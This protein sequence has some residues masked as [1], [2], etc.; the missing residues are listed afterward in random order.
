MKKEAKKKVQGLINKYQKAK[1]DGKLKSYTEEETKKDFILPLFEILGWDVH[2]KNEVSAEESISGKRV[3]YGFYINN[4]VKFYLEAKKI[5]VDLHKEDYANQAIRYAW[6]KGAV[7]ALLTDFESII[8]F[9]AQDIERKLGDKLYFEIRYT[10]YLDRF[11]QLWLLSKEAF[12]NDEL[13]KDAEK[14]G[15]KF[16]KVPV[17]S[18]LYEDLE[19]CREIL[20]K[21]LGQMNRKVD[22]DLLDEGVQKLLDRLIFIRVAE[23]RGIEPK[24]LIPLVRQARKKGGVEIYQSMVEKFREFDDYYNSNLFLPHPFEKWE[25]YSGVTEKVISIL[26]G[27]EGYYE[28]DFKAMPAD[29]L[30]AVYENY[31]GHRLAQSKKGVA[32]SKD[33]RK[34]KEQGIYYTPNFIVDYIVRNTLKPVLD[35]CKTTEDIK[36]IRVLDPACGS[37]SFLVKALEIIVDKYK[38]FEVKKPMDLIKLQ[39]LEDNIY[40]VDLDNQAVELARLNLL[41]NVL[42]KR[43]KL[44][45]LD[46]IKNGNSLIFGTDKELEKYFGENFGEEKPFNWKEEFP[47]VVNQGGFDVIIGN[48]PYVTQKKSEVFNYEWNADLY[49]MFFELALKHNLL[50]EGGYLGYITPRFF[51]VNK[52]TKDVRDYMLKNISI[53]ALVE[54]SPFLDA[55]TECVITIIK[56]VE[57]ENKEIP[58]FKEKDGVVTYMNDIGISSIIQNP[59]SIILTDLTE[60]ISSLLKKIKKNSVSLKD[61]S[62]SRRGME[63]S[64]KDLRNKGNVKALIGEDVNRYSIAYENTHV[65]SGHKEYKRLKDFFRKKNLILLRRVAKCLISTISP[66]VYAFSKNIYGIKITDSNYNPKY[67]LALINS[68]LLSFYYQ[69]KF[70]TKKTSLFPEV[71]TYLFNKLPIKKID[72]TQQN[73]F[74]R[75]VNRILKLQKDLNNSAKNSNKWRMLKDKIEKV[76]KKINKK[77]YKVYGLTKKD[78]KIIEKSFDNN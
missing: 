58:I 59:D 64:K 15:K 13:D 52:N 61:I 43:E 32:V 7:W 14:H 28:Y 25:D 72:K 76:D 23:D 70:S 4:R 6:N 10:E 36:K 74:V 56:N 49:L 5:K 63:I 53:E 47:R 2:N 77:I 38:E 40:G 11:D 73:K 24:T 65:S 57:P 51:L 54:S 21:Q 75:L 12:K 68:K 48:P 8:V 39:I 60:E 22:P 50:K 9:N 42:E 37:G 41:I 69:R 55:N 45:I 71:Q 78:I 30:G 26:Y 62:E 34:R 66:K 44:P 46:N 27:K 19:R 18:L 16:Q 17:T 20:T 67:V 31:L 1:D 35:K 3:D 29:V 33:A